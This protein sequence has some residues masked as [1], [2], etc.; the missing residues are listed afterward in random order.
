MLKHM[1]SI[2]SIEYVCTKRQFLGVCKDEVINIFQVARIQ[3]LL[4]S[5]MVGIY[6]DISYWVSAATNIQ[7]F[8]GHC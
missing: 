6:V 3:R 7:C 8:E 1:R 2:Q 5:V 4:F